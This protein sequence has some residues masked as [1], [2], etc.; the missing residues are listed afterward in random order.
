MSA[1]PV[2]TQPLQLREYLAVLR[3]RRAS[4]IATAG[5]TLA[6]AL[7][8]SLR[9]T[10]M[11]TSTAKVLVKPI[12]ANQQLLSGTS[13]I[14]L[15]LDTESQLVRSAVVAKLAAD[16]MGSAIAPHT[17]IQH[18]GVSVPS[19]TEI[20]EISDSDPSPIRAQRAAQAFADAYLEFKRSEALATYKSVSSSIQGEI[21]DLQQKLDKAQ[22]TSQHSSEG[23]TVKQ[24]ADSDISLLSN[25]IALLRNQMASLT[26]LDIDPGAIVQRANLPEA[27][28]SPNHLLNAALGLFVGLAL[29]VGLAFLRE[30]LDDRLRGRDDLEE[31]LGS[32]TLVV[33]PKISEWKSPEV[34]RL[35]AIEDPR[36]PAAEAYKTLRTS[37]LFAAAQRE[38]KSI[39]VCSAEAGEGKS[40][41]AAN[42]AVVLAQAGKRVVLVSGDLRKPRIARFFQPHGGATETDIGL[43]TVL[44]GETSLQD[45]LQP[46][47]VENLWLLTAGP[48]PAQPAEMAQ[49]SAM[50]VLV[51]ALRQ[52]ADLTIIDSAPTLVVTD[53]AAMAPHVDGVLFVADASRTTRGAVTRARVQLEHVGAVMVGA[54]LNNF[55]PSKQGAY[56][57]EPYRYVYHY[58]YAEPALE[59]DGRSLREAVPRRGRSAS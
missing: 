59:N 57:Y 13:T 41:T 44:T 4:V 1:Q 51:D 52:A 55:D 42:L 39:M 11:F 58:R 26:T 8:V 50:A 56:S 40:T 22:Y 47:G 36:G 28:S 31:H 12:T 19:N 25:Q 45:A 43:S 14:T 38:L 37:V 3:A 6:A 33:I 49:S 24:R 27:P 21:N 16:K 9:M 7:F 53:A 54:V 2:P 15:N 30:R 18:L 29:G 46:S 34:A 32:P 48:V 5:I 17:L 23:S 20:L 35:V 10:P